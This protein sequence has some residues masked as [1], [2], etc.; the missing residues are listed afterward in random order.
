MN[1][2]VL[3]V[4]AGSE[5]PQGAFNFLLRMQQNEPVN[6]LGL[7]FCPID[8]EAIATATQIPIQAPHDRVMAKAHDVAVA[9]RLGVGPRWPRYLELSPLEP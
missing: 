9:Q 7:F 6:V 1:R 8:Y 2:Q 4:C 3:F 5:F